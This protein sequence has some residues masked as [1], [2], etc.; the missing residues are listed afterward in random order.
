[1]TK[2]SLGKAKECAQVT[3]KEKGM[4]QTAELFKTFLNGKTCALKC[5]NVLKTKLVIMSTEHTNGCF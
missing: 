4:S 3:A 5:K 1:M 2:V